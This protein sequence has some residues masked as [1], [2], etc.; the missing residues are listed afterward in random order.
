[1]I[2]HI[3][4]LNELP[5]ALCSAYEKCLL[6]QCTQLQ[7]HAWPN[8]NLPCRDEIKESSGNERTEVRSCEYYSKPGLILRAG[9]F[10][11][12]ATQ[13]CSRAGGLD[14]SSHK[15]CRTCHFKVCVK[16][17]TESGTAKPQTLCM[18][19]MWEVTEH[20]PSSLNRQEEIALPLPSHSQWCSVIHEFHFQ[21]LE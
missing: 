14:W 21:I 18:R 11:F 19:A 12:I 10:S 17:G 4:R 6:K 7:P 20:H 9:G 1:M 13:T 3:W 16:N 2:S 8:K 5:A 15:T